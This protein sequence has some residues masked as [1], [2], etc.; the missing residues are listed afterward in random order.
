MEVIREVYTFR[1][2]CKFLDMKSIILLTSINK[3][4]YDLRNELQSIKYNCAYFNHTSNK[5]NV[6]DAYYVKTN[7]HIYF[8][9]EKFNIRKITGT[10]DK[11]IF[12]N[13]NQEGYVMDWQIIYALG[14][15]CTARR[16]TLV[17]P[18]IHTY[19]PCFQR[20]SK[21]HNTYTCNTQ[22]PCWETC[23]N[24]VIEFPCSV[25]NVKIFLEHY[26]RHVT[27]HFK[28]INSKCYEILDFTL[29]KQLILTAAE[30]VK[31]IIVEF[32]CA[33]FTHK[34]IK[35]I[36]NIVSW[37]KKH[38]EVFILDGPPYIFADVI[39]K[40]KRVHW[41]DLIYDDQR[42]IYEIDKKYLE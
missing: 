24:L 40:K 13:G 5:Q 9:N 28:Q 41:K 3:N 20:I 4:Y 39:A 31:T 22:F 16:V 1:N 10:S 38:R 33:N 7:K 25:T 42:E 23:Y 19:E 27:L 37:N 36:G 11:Y 32:E 6:Y 18:N 34:K 8:D 17:D 35:F 14:Y 2:I 29:T 12:V 15:V 30:R 21:E 26:I